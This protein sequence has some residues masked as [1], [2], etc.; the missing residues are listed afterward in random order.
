MHDSHFSAI[1]SSLHLKRREVS[2]ATCNASPIWWGGAWKVLVNLFV[3]V[4]FIISVKV[5]K[6]LLYVVGRVYILVST[7]HGL[8][9]KFRFLRKALH[10][11][12]LKS[13][14]EIPFFLLH[15]RSLWGIMKSDLHLVLCNPINSTYPPGLHFKK[16]CNKPNFWFLPTSP[17]IFFSLL[18][19]F[20][21]Q[22]I[23]SD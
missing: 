8:K 2:G 10:P 18:L 1:L 20:C 22:N 16:A 23:H 17:E 7:F 6:I 5:Q 12:Q 9:L 14:G 3:A 21:V 4:F 19:P 11:L 15:P 13:K